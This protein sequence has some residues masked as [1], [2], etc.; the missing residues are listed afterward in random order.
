MKREQLKTPLAITRAR[1][2]ILFSGALGDFIC[3]LPTVERI[4]RQSAVELLARR[5]FADLL[6]SSIAVRRLDCDEINRLFVAGAGED[7]SLRRF[8]D[9]YDSIYSWF[10]SRDPVFA[11]ELR[12]ASQ[13][14]AL[15]FPFRP[16][17]GG[18]HQ[19]DY[20]LA[21]I[22]KTTGAVPTILVKPEAEQWCDNY[23]QRYALNRKPVLALAPGSGGREKN[24]PVASYQAVADWWRNRFQGA[25][26]VVL[27]PVED[28]RGGFDSVG[29]GSVVARNLTL[30]QLSALLSRCLLY[31]GNDSG[32]THLA[33]ALGVRTVALFGPS[34]PRQWGPRGEKVTIVRSGLACSPCL[35][36]TMKRCAHRD[37]LGMLEPTVVIRSLEGLPE[38]ASGL[39]RKISFW[40][41]NFLDRG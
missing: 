9:S 26:I 14:K 17:H 25:I 5:E 27:G 21:C 32:P 7:E 23:W 13:D 15:I 12:R 3:L 33:A 10:G 34:D 40:E 29:R 6:S 31:I 41:G 20:Y 39:N 24:W 16:L 36:E 2:L 4:S 22:E 30:G 1:S 19:T 11:N 37:C 35:V 8:F 18:I 28:E 38:L